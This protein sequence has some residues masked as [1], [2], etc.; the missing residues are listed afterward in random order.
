MFVALAAVL[1][2]CVLPSR[3]A[4]AACPVNPGNA[5]S[6][7]GGSGNLGEENWSNGTP[8]STCDVSITAA[9]DYTVTMTGGA[10]MRSLTLGGTGSTPHLVISD[11]SPNTNLDAQPAGI[12][13]A[14]GATVTLTCL[15]GGC[16]GGGP[17]IYSGSSPFANAG[18]ITV[19][20]NTGGGAVVGG[21]IANTGTITF[22][23]SGSLSGQV[24][25]KGSIAVK[26]GAAATNSGSS[27]G[28][29]EPFVKNDTGGTIVGEGT[30]FLS[31]IN[32][33]QGAGTSE[34]VYIPCGSLKYTG[35]GASEVTAGGG[36]NLTGE[37]KANQKLTVS[38]NSVNTNVVLGGNV[39]NKGH[40]TLTCTTT[41]AD[42]SGGSGGGAGFNVA[43][44]QFTNAGTFTVAAASGTGANMDSGSGGTI[45]NT[46]TMNFEQT[47][48]M[49]GVVINK[50]AIEI[51]DGKVVTNS[52][53]SCGDT[54][55]KVVNDTGGSIDAS[56]S[57]TLS[58]IN[59]EQ[60]NG[61]TSGTAPVQIPCG[62]LKYT[63]TG[64]STV[65]ANASMTG[66]IAAGQTLRVLG[67]VSTPSFSNAG[68]IVFDQSTQDATLSGGTVT[69]TGRIEVSGPSAHTAQVASGQ[70]QQTGAGAEVVVPAGT[71]LNPGGMLTLS[72][73]TL[74]GGGT[75]NGN[76]G[77]SGGT[78]K[79][80]DGGIGTLT[81]TG[82]YVQDVARLEIEIAGTGAGQHDVLAVGGVLGING[83]LALLPTSGFASSAAIGDSVPFLSY[84]DFGLGGQFAQTT[85]DPALPCGKVFSTSVD[86]GAK[87][88]KANVVAGN[89]CASGGG[90]VQPP[91]SGP[92][93]TQKRTC[94]K[95]KKLKNG[96]CVRKKCPKGKKLKRGR[97][98]KKQ[99]K[100]RSK[101]S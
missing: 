58:V 101:R 3:A 40:V 68:T 91:P 77:N 100:A 23:K 42:C 12:T 46:G 24:T 50:G 35:T 49:S 59:Y 57:G 41:P 97:C 45:T 15:P 5:T 54:G 27:C 48:R 64:A 20:A 17:D 76:V 34:D 79:P 11:Q 7:L 4:A 53:S 82:S 1:A 89:P 70:I 39:T 29:T 55:P 63:G 83:T 84:N 16:P 85:V 69:N 9:G 13:I 95:G 90:T 73:G 93:V 21:V 87:Q 72:A 96:R 66:N 25:N 71:K 60:G 47:T 37:I 8:T 92:P 14:A 33:E 18:T 88:L 32:F 43:G 52:G 2:L 74:R 28:G 44:N 61:T 94:P 81:V 19:D 30:G 36:F 75:V 6:W 10:N 80:G 22:E 26:D 99:P 31:V 65:Q 98:V 78:V 38:A 56:G 62:S 51:A 86:E 67:Q